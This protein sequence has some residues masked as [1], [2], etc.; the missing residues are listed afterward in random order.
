MSHKTRRRLGRR[1]HSIDTT[2]LE[3][4]EVIAEDTEDD[5]EIVATVLHMLRAGHVRL[6]GNF[7]GRRVDAA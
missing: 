6:I 1:S 4:I 3:L 7:R 5:R 2:L